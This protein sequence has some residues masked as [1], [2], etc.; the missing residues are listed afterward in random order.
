M[1]FVS[2]ACQTHV[3]PLKT[4]HVEGHGNIN[5]YASTYATS[6]NGVVGSA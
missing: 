1:A 2:P 5:G 6:H 3:D 4:N